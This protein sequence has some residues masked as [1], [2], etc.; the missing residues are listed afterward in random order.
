MI[1]EVAQAFGG[2]AQGDDGRL[3]RAGSLGDASCLSFYPTKNLGGV[4]DAGAAAFRD[5]AHRTH[6]TSLRNHG[7]SEHG[8]DAAGLN[9]R[10][11]ELHAVFLKAGLDDIEVTLDRRL[12]IARQYL[13]ALAGVGWVALPDSTT[14][15]AWNYFVIRHPRRDALAEMLSDQKVTTR[16]YYP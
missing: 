8:H 1:E 3:H 11:D 2:L 10:M 14:G 12:V 4:G 5:S 6:T 13:E 16:F 7:Y 15:H 9:N